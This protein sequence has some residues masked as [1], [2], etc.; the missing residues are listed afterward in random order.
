MIITAFV[1][2]LSGCNTVENKVLINNTSTISEIEVEEIFL[3]DPRLTNVVAV[4]NDKELLAGV[5][6]KT[7]SRFKKTK[8]E[9]ELKE[10][11]EKLHSEL[12]VIVSADLKIIM[13]TKKMMEETDEKKLSK[14]IKK[15]KSLIK[16]ET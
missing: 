14:S 16:E 12:N 9:K 10:K 6:V 8:I 3:N 5:T 4:I 13:E 7:F 15:L 1:L 2:L 11:I